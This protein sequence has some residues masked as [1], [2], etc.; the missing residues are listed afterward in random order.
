MFRFIYS[1]VNQKWFVVKKQ[2]DD[3][4]YNKC[5]QQAR[6]HSTHKM[7]IEIIQLF[8]KSRKIRLQNRENVIPKHDHRIN[9]KIVKSNEQKFAKSFDN[10]TGT[11]NASG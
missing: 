2:N 4:Y 9:S 8:L 5:C 3:C 6:Y 7:I 10:D 11:L 1:R